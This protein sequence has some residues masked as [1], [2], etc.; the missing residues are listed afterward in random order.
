MRQIVESYAGHVKTKKNLVCRE[1]GLAG[2]IERTAK[3]AAPAY[4]AKLRWACQNKEQLG[5]QG[6]GTCKRYRETC[7]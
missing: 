3:A 1:P 4:V 5:F 6:A 7:T 2:V